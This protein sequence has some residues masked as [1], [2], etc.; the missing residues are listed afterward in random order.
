[1]RP[2]AAG[3]AA[4]ALVEGFPLHFPNLTIMGVDYEVARQAGRLVALGGLKTPRAL[5][6]ATAL[7]AGI[8]IVVAND[9]RWAGRDHRR[10]PHGH[11]LLPRGAY[12]LVGERPHRELGN[13]RSAQAVDSPHQGRFRMPCVPTRRQTM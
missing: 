2:F 1:V 6:I 11:A 12:A 10:G 8:P 7:S 3:G 4:V 13:D 9:A 5:V